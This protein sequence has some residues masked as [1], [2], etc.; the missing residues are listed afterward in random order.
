MLYINNI[1]ISFLLLTPALYIWVVLVYIHI[2]LYV[3]GHQN[4]LITCKNHFIIMTNKFIVKLL[5]N[6]GTL[7]GVSCLMFRV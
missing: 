2:Y 3:P 1:E 5:R 6:E 7:C 4:L